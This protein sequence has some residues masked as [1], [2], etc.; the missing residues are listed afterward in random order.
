[1]RI[2]LFL[3][4]IIACSFVINKPIDR[5]GVKG[6]FTFNEKIFNIASADKPRDN[7]Y[8]QEYLPE[9]ETVEHFN[10]MLT[11]HLFVVDISLK[12]AVQKKIN[13]LDL[14][15][16]SDPTC[17][18]KV[19]QSPDGKEFIVDFLLGEHKGDKMTIAEFNIYRYRQ[20]K[21]KG[22]KSAILVFSY[23][24]RAYG[25]EITSF[26]EKLGTN[27]KNLLNEIITIGMP[28]LNI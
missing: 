8:I 15:K 18:Y 24:K 21:I 4:T 10:Q 25:D 28:T 22:N 16:K 20:I 27:R 23:S 1:M 6:P 2:Y 17:N 7:Y 12:D 5:I 13:E 14:R 9:Q 3:L 19:S 11:I 26:Y